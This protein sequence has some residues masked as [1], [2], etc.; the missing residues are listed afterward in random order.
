MNITTNSVQFTTNTTTNSQTN[1]SDTSTEFKQ[2]LCSLEEVQKNEET[3]K[4][5][6]EKNENVETSEEESVEQVVEENNNVVENAPKPDNM[7]NALD[8]LQNTV[9][10]INNKKDKISVNKDIELINNDMNLPEPLM[11]NLEAGMSFNSNGQPF[12]A[13]VQQQDNQKLGV[14]ESDLLEEKAILSSME[15]NIALVN[16]A[17]I[18]KG[19]SNPVQQSMNLDDGIKM[20]SVIM[21]K[22]DVDFFVNLV[23]N[24]EIELSSVNNA[25]KSAQVSKTLADLLAKAM[26]EN[27][28]VRIDFD[29]DI[30]VIIRISKDG[31]ISADFLPSS[32]IAEAYLKE[33]LPLLKQRFEE[34][35]IEYDELNQ[36]K[37]QRQNEKE[38]KKKG[39]E[40]E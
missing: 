27:K 8:V 32:Q 22:G 34:N 24:S 5:E 21:S 35:N 26:N 25:Q 39:R 17:R 12:S 15:E 13:F 11:Q 10:E 37:Q 1:N 28:P 6:S 16:R 7:N 14:N 33:N 30:S 9:E 23:N 2:E 18:T 19:N 20:D 31:K 4:L 38:D 29:N 3:T 40:N 36:R